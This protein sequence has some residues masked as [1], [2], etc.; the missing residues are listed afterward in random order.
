MIPKFIS[1]LQRRRRLIIHGDGQHSGRYIYAGDAADAFDTIPHRGQFGQVYNI[2]S[3][4]EVTNLELCAKLPAVFNMSQTESGD[5]IEHTKGRPFNDHRHTVDGRRTGTVIFPAGGDITNAHTI[6][7]DHGTEC[8][9]WGFAYQ[10]RPQFRRLP[11]R[12]P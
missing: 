8:G 5:W 1:L 9:S 11:V 10:R 12:T 2:G 6:P 3:V 4:D 7:C